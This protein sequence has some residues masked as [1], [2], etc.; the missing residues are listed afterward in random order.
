[1]VSR[2]KDTSF[3]WI[4]AFILSSQ[5]LYISRKNSITM[6]DRGSVVVHIPST[7]RL[8]I[9]KKHFPRDRTQW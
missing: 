1:M 6:F 3:T 4:I 8:N 5:L 7:A 9:V 2:R